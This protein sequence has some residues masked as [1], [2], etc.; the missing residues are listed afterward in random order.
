MKIIQFIM[1][2]LMVILSVTANA[3]ERVYKCSGEAKSGG[4]FEEVKVTFTKSSSNK[5]LKVNTIVPIWGKYTEKE[6]RGPMGLP[7]GDLKS[8]YLN[9]TENSR[10][11]PWK[12]Y[13][14]LTFDGFLEKLNFD[15]LPNVLNLS[16]D[17]ATNLPDSYLDRVGDVLNLNCEIF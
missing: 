12:G 16:I 10:I 15:E 14:Y 11:N 1:T 8:I 13:S 5:I 2:L 17:Y 3:D 6:F 9:G 4:K 7:N